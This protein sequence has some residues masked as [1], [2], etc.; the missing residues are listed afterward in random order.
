MKPVDDLTGKTF[1]RWTVIAEAGRCK[2][3]KVLWMAR[4]ECGQIRSV[5]GS[6]L[7]NGASRSCGCLREETSGARTHGR[8]KSAMYQSYAT[9]ISRCHNPK[10]PKYQSYGARGIVVCK[11]WR[12]DF[13]AFLS[14]MGERPTG[15]TLDRID[16]DGNY[17]P[18]NCRWAT[19]EEQ[20]ANKR[21]TVRIMHCGRTLSLAEWSRETGIEY[22]TIRQRIYR[23]GWDVSRAL[24]KGP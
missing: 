5:V 22:G 4:C 9:M 2:F 7:K 17:E 3:N 14:D 11:R 20:Q 13:A 15:K 1:A 19:A 24:T 12:E 8:S 21:N 16:N 23:Y 18:N 10:F 6:N